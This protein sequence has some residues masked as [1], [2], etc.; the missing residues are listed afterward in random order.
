MERE[1]FDAPRALR[2]LRACGNVGRMAAA[3]ART[4]ARVRRGRYDL[5]YC[6]GTTADFVGGLVARLTGVPALW[7]V[8]YT[9]LPAAAAPLHRWLS[10]SPAVRRVVCVSSAAAAAVVPH[11]PDKVVV[12]NNGVDTDAFAP[13]RL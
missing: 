9:S 2:W 10:G 1:D 4:A 8:R 7:H 11:C 6:N 13:G 3:I 12:I 5:V